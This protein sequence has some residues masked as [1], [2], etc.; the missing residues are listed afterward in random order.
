MFPIPLWKDIFSTTTTNDNRLLSPPTT[1]EFS[2]DI[3]KFLKLPF[4]FITYEEFNARTD[5][6]TLHIRATMKWNGE[7]FKGTI[8][9]GKNVH[10]SHVKRHQ[11]IT[12]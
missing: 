9:N 4:H 3:Y 6:S 12:S 8:E 1:Y 5:A 10:Y 2:L 7:V 11:E